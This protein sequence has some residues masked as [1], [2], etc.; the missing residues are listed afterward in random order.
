M[1]EVAV[2]IASLVGP[3]LIALTSNV[4]KEV[5]DIINSRKYAQSGETLEELQKEIIDW[6][7]LLKVV[8]RVDVRNDCELAAGQ[9]HCD[10][11]KQ[12]LLDISECLREFQKSSSRKEQFHLVRRLSRLRKS[13]E[14]R[15]QKVNN[16]MAE[17]NTIVT[18]LTH[19]EL[20]RHNER[21]SQT[22]NVHTQKLDDIQCAQVE[23]Q[24]MLLKLYQRVRSIETKLKT[25][26]ASPSS[27]GDSYNAGVAG[28]TTELS[29]IADVLCSIYL[30]VETETA[31]SKKTDADIS[32]DNSSEV[33]EK[34]E[35][36]KAKSER[37]STT[38]DRGTQT[39]ETTEGYLAP[40]P[41]VERVGAIDTDPSIS[42]SPLRSIEKRDSGSADETESDSSSSTHS[43]GAVKL[44]R[45]KPAQAKS[46]E[47]TGSL[48]KLLQ[49]GYSELVPG[50]FSGSR[51]KSFKIPRITRAEWNEGRYETLC[52]RGTI[53]IGFA[54]TE[55]YERRLESLDLE[56]EAI[57]CPVPLLRGP[58]S[59]PRGNPNA[60]FVW[61]TG[62]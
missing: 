43:R 16:W 41:M 54:I 6:S 20:K 47:T 49:Q 61:N 13:L 24:P 15:R 60:L 39:M 12:T 46:D 10:K 21:H 58:I 31:L 40:S 34:C 62:K 33:T 38:V 52:V 7:A 28:T 32:Y 53:A 30:R 27:L 56:Y 26:A 48:I 4:C 2:G 29:A 23:M 18:R 17:T 42:S 36:A 9:R 59:P 45:P 50:S 51:F 3:P 44:E 22:L 57:K 1:A 55:P 19:E 37:S 14:L 5:S 25:H 35:S 8:E 11:Y